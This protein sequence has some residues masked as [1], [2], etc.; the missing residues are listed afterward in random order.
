MLRPLAELYRAFGE[1]TRLR[2]LALLYALGELCVCDVEAALGVSQ[3][4]ASRHLVT[5]RRAGLLADR[6]VGTWVYYRIAEDL[7]DPARAALESLVAALR[8]DPT[9]CADARRA[10]TRRRSVPQCA[11]DTPGPSRPSASE[12]RVTP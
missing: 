7:S 11:A 12:D 9:V 8:E 3:S 4:K 2:M 1:E 6:R 10:R 5:L